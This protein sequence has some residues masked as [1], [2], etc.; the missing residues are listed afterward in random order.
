[1]NLKPKKNI[2]LIDRIVRITIGV[3]LIIYSYFQMSL[4]ALFFGIFS[5]YEGLNSWC[6]L[7]QLIGINTCPINKKD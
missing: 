6:I 1:M 2:G 4:L 7:Y 5:I 3:A